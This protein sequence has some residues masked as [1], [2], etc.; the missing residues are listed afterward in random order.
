[1]LFVLNHLLMILD[2]NREGLNDWVYEQAQ[3]QKPS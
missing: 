3:G 1:M 2:R